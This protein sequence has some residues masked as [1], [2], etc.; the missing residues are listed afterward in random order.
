MYSDEVIQRVK[1]RSDI[2][3]IISGYVSL[4]KAGKNY[5]GLCP[6]HTEKTPSFSVS[7]DRQMYHCFGCGVGG[8]VF[9]FI[10]TQ[11]GLSFP[12]AVKRLAERAGVELP[13]GVGAAEQ[14]QSINDR[15]ALLSVNAD[16]AEYFRRE[17][18]GPG[19]SA[20]RAYLE[21]RGLSESVI[22]DFGLGY[23]R[24]ERD[25]LLRH[26]KQKEYAPAVIE[27]AGLIIK[28]SEGGGYYD[29]FRGRIMFPIHDI[30]GNI[31]A[32][33]G[34]VMDDSLPKYMNSPE[35]PLYSKSNILYGLDRAKDE[36]R[37][38]GYFLVVEG[39][40]DAIA[41]HQYGARNAVATLGTA[42]TE[43][44][45][46][47]LRRFAQKIVM[48]FD[49]DPA[50]I[51]ATLRSLDLFAGSGMKVNVLS[52]PGGDDPDAFLKKHGYEAFA[53]RLRDSARLMDFALG[54]IAA[55]MPSGTIEEKVEAARKML[56]LVSRL[57]SGI[58]RDHYLKK[59]ADILDI[60][61]GLLRQEMSGLGRTGAGPKERG[62]REGASGSRPHLR[63]R[64]EEILIHLMLK[65]PNAAIGIKAQISPEE[66]TDPI[67]R[68]AAER[69]FS[70]LESGRRL[71]EAALA[72]EEGGELAQIIS[73][74]VVMEAEYADPEKTCKDCVARIKE[75][76]RARKM[77]AI[78]FA[79]KDAEAKG[80]KEALS[81]LLNEQKRLLSLR[82]QARGCGGGK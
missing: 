50:G 14:K 71:D 80:D 5:V 82:G 62:G 2:V 29:R 58:E 24:R 4:R 51:R 21:K 46:R 19:G 22:E 77:K 35:T 74:L 69:I 41:C 15:R 76:W 27:K 53:A 79:I 17:L 64:A 37:R 7:P 10:E 44:H 52:L 72:R 1:E 61:E 6:F 48:V 36:A 26:L 39:Y 49:P 45:L 81:R 65:D 66:F 13:A 47:L 28:R 32:F 59:A 56:E 33:G 9:S 30:S 68:R 25:G 57:Q 23:S 16:A 55:E 67:L 20:A 63:P 73:R 54:H 43:G 78:V 11:E 70:A 31:I 42:L 8:D 40:L 12:E 3:E 38:L 34:R 18:A 60:D 75:Q